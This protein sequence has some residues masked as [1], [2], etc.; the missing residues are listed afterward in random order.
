M[1]KNKSVSVLLFLIFSFQFLQ[2]IQVEITLSS[3]MVDTSEDAYEIS[4]KIVILNKSTDYTIKG[5]CSE[6]G[7]E[8]KKGTSPTITLSSI[9]ID[10]SKTGPFVIKKNCEVKLILINFKRK[11]YYNR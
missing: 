9:N 10:N 4:N 1:F 11:I 8:V 6:C 3:S 5:T 7:I 2:T